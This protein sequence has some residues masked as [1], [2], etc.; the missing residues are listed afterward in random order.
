MTLRAQFFVA[1]CLGY[2]I[3]SYLKK[4]GLNFLVKPILKSRKKAVLTFLV[5][6]SV[7]CS[8]YDYL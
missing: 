5:A 3:H 7:I 2:V 8:F 4:T 6:L 1:L